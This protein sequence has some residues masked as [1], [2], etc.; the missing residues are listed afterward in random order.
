MKTKRLLSLMV[1]F[2]LVVAVATGCGKTPSSEQSSQPNETASAAPSDDANPAEVGGP[3]YGGVFKYGT[4]QNLSEIG[5]PAEITNNSPMVFLDPVLQSL[6]IYAADG[7][8]EPVLAETWETDADAKTITFHLRK[9]VMFSD[10]TDF[11][12][13]AVKWN[14]EQYQENKRSEVA[15]ISSIDVV[16]DSTVTLNLTDWNSSTLAAVAVLVR[17]ISPTAFQENGKDW[18]YENPVGTGPFMLTKWEKNVSLSYEKN[19]NYWEEGKPYVDEVQ[20]LIIE[21]PQTLAS[22]LE[23][24]EVDAVYGLSVDI[25]KTLADTGKYQLVDD[26]TGIGAVGI[27]LIADCTTEGSAFADV[28][29]RQALCYAIDSQAIADAFFQGY[30]VV[31]NQWGPPGVITYNP[32]V[33]G[34][35]YDPD[36]AKALLAEAGYPDGFECPLSCVA[37]QK[38]M[39]TAIQAQLAEVGIN[40]KLEVVEEAKQQENYFNTWGGGLMGHFHSVT[41]DLGLYMWRHLAP[42]GAF[43]AKGILHPD[44]VVELLKENQLAATEEIKKETSMEIQKLVYDTYCLVGKPLVIP[45]GLFLEQLFVRDSGIG[46]KHYSTWEPQNVWL[47]K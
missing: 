25:T 13:D 45:D 37:A 9:N 32:D 16:D 1:V 38:D 23:A 14:I 28:K 34:Y 19:P 4:N 36:K 20:M 15:S 29:V 7:S 11:N 46:Q 27:G 22:S 35:P 47:D 30:A 42:D 44:D 2:L 43:Y 26:K 33:A 24:G 6:A 39:F 5:Y 18:T 3:K 12:A 21:D 17:Y 10:G 41:P 40:A 8:L 31:T